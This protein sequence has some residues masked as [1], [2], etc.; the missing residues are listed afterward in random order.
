LL[1][2]VEG[3][4]LRA[5]DKPKHSKQKNHT[6]LPSLSVALTGHVGGTTL[7]NVGG[8]TQWRTAGSGSPGDSAACAAAR[9]R[10][11]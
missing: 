3:D 1:K 4:A 9:S 7:G 10:S 8:D 11:K 5:A 6:H 2:I